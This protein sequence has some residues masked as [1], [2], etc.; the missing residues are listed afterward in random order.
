MRATPALSYETG[1]P[2][3]NG[4]N[5]WVV[6]PVTHRPV[7]VPN[8]NFVN[9]GYN[10]YFLRDPSQPYNAVTNPYIGNLGTQEGG[11]PNTLRTPPQ[12][13]RL[14]ARRGR[15]RAAPDAVR[16][17]RQPAR[18]R[19]ADATAGQSVPDRAARLRGRQSQLRVHLRTDP[20][21][22]REGAVQR[23]IPP[24]RSRT[25]S[26]TACPPTTASRRPCPGPTAAR[27]TCRG[28]RD[29]ALGPR[30]PALPLLA[31]RWAAGA[32]RRCSASRDTM[33]NPKIGVVGVGRMGANMARRLKDVGYPV[34]AV[35][36]VVP[37]RPPRS[38]RNSAPNAPRR[39]R[40]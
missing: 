6:D 30:R 40:A 8:D 39:R 23:A 5:T 21:R 15:P 27:G 2:Y 22:R 25:C 19:H 20:R 1:Y 29:G 24:A 14:A 37:R 10:Y 38:R 33:S 35:Y 16:R 26:A 11:D 32:A 9:P 13:A 3:G 4:R 18:R 12:T 31:R 36:D 17:R 28:L 7:A 34:V